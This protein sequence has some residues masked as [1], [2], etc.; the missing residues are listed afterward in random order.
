LVPIHKLS[1]DIKKK[2]LEKFEKKR[3]RIIKDN[4]NKALKIITKNF[5]KKELKR[6]INI[7]NKEAINNCLNVP[8]NK[9][10]DY[11]NKITDR[12]K[13]IIIGSNDHTNVMVKL[14]KSKLEKLKNIKYYEIKDNDIYNYKKK[15][16]ILNYVKS[17][18]L[19]NYDKIII[20][21]Y[22][23]SSEILEKINKKYS[24]LNTFSPY[25]NGSRSIIDY[26]YIKKFKGKNKIYSKKLF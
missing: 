16:R 3:E 2:L 4:R 15:I 18:K 8:F 13:L 9:I 21:S 24:S 14:F 17:L 26:Y 10:N 1:I 23:Y 19:D 5:S 22:Q 12:E 7:N 6:K 25:D 11:L 20:S